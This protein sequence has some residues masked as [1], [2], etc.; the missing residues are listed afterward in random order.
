MVYSNRVKPDNRKELMNR[1]RIA[2]E[3]LNERGDIINNTVQHLLKRV[4]LCLENDG[5]HFEHLLK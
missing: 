1:I 5:G 4:R 3:E 2:V